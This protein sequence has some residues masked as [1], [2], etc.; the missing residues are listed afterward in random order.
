[1]PIFHYNDLHCI[2]DLCLYCTIVWIIYTS[3][4]PKGPW[5]QAQKVDDYCLGSAVIF[6]LWSASLSHARAWRVRVPYLYWLLLFCTRRY[7]VEPFLLNFPLPWPNYLQ[8]PERMCTF[9]C[10]FENPCDLW[11][12]DNPDLIFCKNQIIC[13]LLQTESKTKW[14]LTY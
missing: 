13:V 10:G 6:A 3:V 12:T 11:N 1:M 7:S 4:H 9:A 2:I 14:S 5:S 8:I